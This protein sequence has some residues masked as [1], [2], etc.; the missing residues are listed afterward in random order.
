MGVRAVIGREQRYAE[1]G[2]NSL[3]FESY[4][5]SNKSQF[6]AQSSLYVYQTVFFSFPVLITRQ[7][8]C[9]LGEFLALAS[10]GF[11]CT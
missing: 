9:S 10:P 7:G 2:P 6:L 1:L 3:L 8:S 5:V 4:D 11:R